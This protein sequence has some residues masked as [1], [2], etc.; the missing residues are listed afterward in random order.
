[1]TKTPTE[2]AQELLDAARADYQ[3]ANSPAAQAAYRE[4]VGQAR[5]NGNAAAGASGSRRKAD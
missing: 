3:R 5:T 2:A 1:M 4:A